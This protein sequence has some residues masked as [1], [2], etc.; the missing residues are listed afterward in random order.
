MHRAII[1]APNAA[2]TS[3]GA[4]CRVET[5]PGAGAGTVGSPADRM[6]GLS[7]PRRPLWAGSN[8]GDARGV[9]ARRMKWL[10]MGKAAWAPVK[11]RELPSSTPT[12]TTV[13]RVGVNPTNQASRRSSVVPV[14]PAATCRNPR[15]RAAVAVPLSSTLLSIRV[16]RNALS[17]DATRR[18]TS[19]VKSRTR[20]PS[21]SV[22]RTIPASG[23]LTPPLA[24]TVY[25]RATCSGVASNT[26]SA[27]VGYGG[28][29]TLPD[30]AAHSSATCSSPVRSATFTAATFRDRAS[31]IRAVIGPSYTP[32]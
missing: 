4:R 27:S 3:C 21:A 15:R 29:V 12:H 20:F 22:T 14:L 19:V 8:T 23:I 9:S 26:P 5:T 24:R 30:A 28:G 31:A 16:T 13:R 18:G 11:P 32:P 2:G 6:R 25:A 1:P 7:P 10:H 17:A